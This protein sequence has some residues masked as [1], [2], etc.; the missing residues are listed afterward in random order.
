MIRSLIVLPIVGLVGCLPPLDES[1]RRV[2]TDAGDAMVAEDASDGH[3]SACSGGKGPN[4]VIEDDEDCDDGNLDETDGCTSDCRLDCPESTG[5]LNLQGTCYFLQSEATTFA[6]AYAQCMSAGNGAHVLTLR[7]ADESGT[8]AKLLTKL[9]LS[10]VM[11]GLRVDADGVTWNS[12]A[13]GEPGWSAT[14]VCPGCYSNWSSGQPQVDVTRRVP[15]MNRD[16]SWKW[17][18]ES[19]LEKFALVC[20]RERPGRPKNECDKDAGCDPVTTYVFTPKWGGDFTYRIQYFPASYASAKAQCE[21]DGYKL[22]DLRTE[23]ERAMVVRYGPFISF[24]TGLERS[25]IAGAWEW[26]DGSSTDTVPWADDAQAGQIGAGSL[27]VTTSYD[28]NLMQARLPNVLQAS[29]CRKEV[30][31]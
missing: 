19:Y 3:V 24:W 9:N 29:V 17:T 30:V 13:P 25:G 7:T 2:Q 31:R 26:N 27:V 23:E 12:V 22:I 28:T 18:V 14:K 20:E 16:V 4:A 5:F 10:K 8:V 21:S 6:E 11:V 1:L 15:V